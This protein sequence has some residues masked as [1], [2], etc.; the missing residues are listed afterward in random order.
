MTSFLDS[1]LHCCHPGMALF[2]LTTT[3]VER[4]K[5]E[6]CHLFR[7]K[8][9]KKRKKEQKKPENG[10][11]SPSSSKTAAAITEIVLCCLYFL[12]CCV[13]F[14]CGTKQRSLPEIMQQWQRKRIG[15]FVQSLLKSSQV[16]VF[17]AAAFNTW[18]KDF[19]LS[20]LS[21]YERQAS[22]VRKIPSQM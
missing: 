20:W 19:F 1:P 10:F 7:F 4:E 14:V 13:A 17:P 15:C 8:T 16:S 2:S 18:M 12:W 6:W 11:S 3:T 9:E 21:L 22:Y 5:T